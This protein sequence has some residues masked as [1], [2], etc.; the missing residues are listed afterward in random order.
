M[1]NETKTIIV[2]HEDGKCVH[3]PRT[4]RISY[5]VENIVPERTMRI[6]VKEVP[7]PHPLLIRQSNE[8]LG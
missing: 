7:L 4:M 3:P 1:S 2:R 8:R 6:A 5:T